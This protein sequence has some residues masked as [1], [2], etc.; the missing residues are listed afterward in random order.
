MPYNLSIL[1]FQFSFS[2]DRARYYHSDLS[3]WISVDPLSDKYPNLSPY[4]YC[5]DNPVRLVDE[6]GRAWEI[7]GETYTP[8]KQYCG[9]QT[10]KAAIIWNEMEKIYA[11]PLG[12]KVIDKMN[13]ESTVYKISS[14]QCPY[15]DDKGNLIDNP[16]Y[17]DKDKTIYLNSEVQ[18]MDE[19]IISHEMFHGYQYLLGQGGRTVHNEVEAYMFEAVVCNTNLG[20][21]GGIALYDKMDP[22]YEASQ[23][24]NSATT[25]FLLKQDWTPEGFNSIFNDIREGFLKFSRANIGGTY[26]GYNTGKPLRN[27]LQELL[28]E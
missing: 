9:D 6:D 25:K 5:A 27:L 1:S 2:Y 20:L 15:K 28:F 3:I 4:T 17:Y 26:N 12:K 23:K 7:E 10:S 21:L 8:G 11:T 19:S 16:S 13:D 18:F 14:K 24:Y 22:M